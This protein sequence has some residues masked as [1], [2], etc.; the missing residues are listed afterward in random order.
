MRVLLGLGV[1]KMVER[2]EEDDSMKETIMNEILNSTQQIRE[3]SGNL[4]IAL[5]L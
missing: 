5:L 3:E 4:W 2:D 1:R